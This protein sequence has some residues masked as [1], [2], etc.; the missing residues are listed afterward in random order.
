M[1]TRN[2]IY[3]SLC[4][5]MEEVGFLKIDSNYPVAQGRREKELIFTHDLLIKKFEDDGFKARAKKF[6]VKPLSKEIDCDIGFVNGLTTPLLGNL[7]NPPNSIDPDTKEK[8]W[9]NKDDY[10]ALDILLETIDS[11]LGVSSYFPENI[12]NDGGLFEGLK[13]RITVNRYERN[14]IARRKCIEHHGISCKV[15]GFDFFK[16]YG[17]IGKDYI[18]VHHLTPL[19]TINENYKIDYVNDLIPVCPN[20]HAMLHRKVDNVDYNIEELRYEILR[21]RNSY[22]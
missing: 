4:S 5:K 1:S 20:C 3:E 13:S 14:I 21:Q 15:C 12:D 11:Y 19:H 10:K 7:F 18:H 6:Y 8:A 22:E 2:H 9:V 16:V 17:E